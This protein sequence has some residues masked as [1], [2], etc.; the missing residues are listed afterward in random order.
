[1]TNKSKLV[2]QAL[3][4]TACSTNIIEDDIEK[5]VDVPD[6]TIVE[7]VSFSVSPVTYTFSFNGGVSDVFTVT[8]GQSWSLS[9][10]AAWLTMSKKNTNTFVAI[11]ETNTATTRR[12]GYVTVSGVD[13]AVV[14]NVLQW[15]TSDAQTNDN[16]IFVKGGTFTMGCTSEQGNDCLQW[17]YP[18]HSV[19]VNDFYIGRYEV[20][21]EEWF[22]VMG[23]YPAYFRGTNMPVEQ[24]SWNDIV[25]TSGTGE[26]IN[27]IHYFPDGFI[28]KLNMKTGKKFRLPTEAEWEY[29]ARGGAQSRGCKYCGSDSPS[30]V[31]WYWDNSGK[32][33]HT[34]GSKAPNE[35]GI[36][37][38][39]GNV[40]EW[41]SDLWDVYTGSSQGVLHPEITYRILRGGP[42]SSGARSVRVSRRH[43][44]VPHGYNR[45]IGFRLASGL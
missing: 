14:V 6:P 1:M 16:M 24:V 23:T 42:W 25:G 32:K 40:W 17:E 3:I 45:T 19:T 27:G 44:V 15:G 4:L 18:A 31:A 20:T 12:T 34:I 8:S 41:C 10:N 37:D 13:T 22:D 21:Q 29:A 43:N 33:P 36:Y 35:L 11:A 39:C 30:E 38:M 9:S 5:P 28:Y 2:A 7:S 26:I